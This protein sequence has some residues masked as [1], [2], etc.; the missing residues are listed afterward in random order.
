MA[1]S[2]SMAERRRDEGELQQQ[3][4]VVESANRTRDHFLAMFSHE[5]RTPLTPVISALES[6]ETEPAQT[7]GD[8]SV[9]PKS[10][11]EPEI[12][13]LLLID[14]AGYSKL[15]NNEQIELLQELNQIVRST[16]CFRSA[17]ASGKLN[18]VPMGDGMALLFFRSPEEPVR[19]ALEISGALRDYPHIRLRMGVHSGPVN[20]ITDVNDKTNI[21]GSGINVAQRVLDCGDA[22]HILLSAHIA[23]DLAQ[24]RHW[25]PSLHDLGECEVKHGL[26]LHLFNLYKDG[27][28]NPQVPEKLRRGRRK[29][30]SGVSV[31]PI[32]APRWPRIALPVALLVSTVALV[33]SPLI[34]FHRATPTTTG[35]PV[36][37][38]T[39]ASALVAIPEKSIA[40]LPFENLSDEKE[41]A[42]FADGVQDEILT[43]L[44]KVADLKVISR[45]SVMQDKTGTKRNLREIAEDLGVAHVLEGSVQRA[46][47]RV[48]VSAQ[49]I[50][51]R[52]DAHL[53]AEHYDR[54]LADVFAIQSEVAENIV[55]Q[56]KANP[57]TS[58]KAAIDLRPTRD[59]EAF[60]LYL[61]AKELI[62]T[63]HDTPDWKDTLLK[64]IRLLDKAISRDG[65]FALA[66]CLATRANEALYWFN[67]D[68]TPARL[69]QAKASAQKALELAPD[70]GEAHLAQALVYYHGDRDYARAREEL[71]IARRELPNDAEVYSVTGWIDRRQGRWQDAVENQEKAAELDPRNSKILN[72]LAILYDVLR[73]YDEEESLVDRAIAANPAT[74]TYFQLMG[75]EIELQKGNRETARKL[76]DGLP[77][78]YDPDGAATST[79]IDLALYQ[80]DPASAEKILAESKL[81]ELVGSTGSLLPRSWFEGLIARA[82]GDAQKA[83]DA[84]V[85][86]GSKIEAKLQQQPYDGLLLSMAGLIDAGLGRDKEALAKGRR[87]V[88]LRPIGDDALDGAVVITNLAMTYAWLGDN[89]SAIE[90]LTFLAKAPG[91]PDYGQLKF[92]PAWDGLRSDVR[93]TK[94]VEGLRPA[95]AH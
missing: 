4:V 1:L 55:A 22:G 61:Q 87:A 49:L 13:H 95:A 20:R 67:L 85:V 44:S 79:R 48:R 54:D 78:G 19:C 83:R 86:A 66:Y 17:E 71:A 53:R 10:D 40:V 39:A 34:F 76:L 64:A 7:E 46:G 41:N 23:E 42:Y 47:G 94:I 60:D 52:S 5:L 65:K 15:S 92:D 27:L 81:E 70:L 74:A 37:G 25:Q 88:E 18:R 16:E 57:A 69:A 63:F 32:S 11:L 26:R 6:L 68:H 2:A 75:A 50:D 24:Y 28:G 12:A 82:Q 33:I 84:F 38:A 31:R 3:K 93:F 36:P 9:E 51:A 8:R 21:A 35:A 89:D 72:D 45:T 30:A 73:R 56:L 43:D 59:P 58:E 80:R 14:V 29:H 90:R 77:S 91:G 62:N